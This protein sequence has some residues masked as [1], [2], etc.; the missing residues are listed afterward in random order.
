MRF[1]KTVSVILV[2]LTVICAGVSADGGGGVLFGYQS[3]TYPFFE[4][5]DVR[6]NNM[7]L[8]YSGGYG[9]GIDQNGVIGGGFGYGIFD[10]TEKT[11][12]GGGFGGFISGKRLLTRPVTISIVSWTGF[13][14]MSTGTY[15]TD[16]GSGFFCVLEE[17]DLEIGLPVFSWFMPTVFVGY[18]V[19]GNVVPGQMFETFL[20]YT[21][22]FGMRI[23]WGSF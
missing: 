19:V 20:S 18:Q 8:T 23:Q 22:V 15:E 2:L 14:G 17:I 3:A 21:P 6:N 11:E 10:A 1:M 12:I 5:Y 16:S 4:N 7:G 13:G 9:Y